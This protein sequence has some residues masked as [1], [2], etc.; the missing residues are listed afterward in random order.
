MNW[1]L[2]NGPGD[3]KAQTVTRASAIDYASHY[4]DSGAFLADLDRRVA[5]RTESQ[6]PGQAATGF[7]ID[8]CMAGHAHSVTCANDPGSR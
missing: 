4:F 8:V 5:F 2:R 7:E 1:L 3:G 6:D